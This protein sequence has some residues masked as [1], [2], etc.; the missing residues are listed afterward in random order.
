[1][2]DRSSKG[3]EMGSTSIYNAMYIVD[4]QYYTARNGDWGIGNQKRK[5]R[6]KTINLPYVPF[7]KVSI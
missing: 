3:L 6:D 7:F 1:M 5:N 4:I 2:R